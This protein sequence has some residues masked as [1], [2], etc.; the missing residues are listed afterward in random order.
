MSYDK[1]KDWSL[2]QK[3]IIPEDAKKR[4]LGHCRTEAELATMLDII[5]N[6]TVYL[7]HLYQVIKRVIP[8]NAGNPDLQVTHLSIKLRSK[9]QIKDWRHFQLIK[10]QLC[11]RETIG[12]E[13]YPPESKLVDTANQYHLWVFPNDTY[14][15][16]IF[17]ERYVTES[18]LTSGKQ[19]PFEVKPEDL[20]SFEEMEEMVRKAKLG[21]MLK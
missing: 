17:Q 14:F 18:A 19:R 3:A 16:F 13:I 6:E 20:K 2:L 9:E 10:N 4:M 5:E 1:K 8:N 7:N 21:A 12:I 15:G 11:G